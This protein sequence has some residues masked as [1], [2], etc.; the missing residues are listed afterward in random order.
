[1]PLTLGLD[2]CSLKTCWQPNILAC[3]R[4]KQPPSH[5]CRS[6]AWLHCCTTTICQPAFVPSWSANT[7]VSLTRAKAC[8]GDLSVSK[9]HQT[10]GRAVSEC[11][12]LAPLEVP[13]LVGIWWQWNRLSIFKCTEDGRHC[14]QSDV[15]VFM[16]TTQ[17]FSSSCKSCKVPFSKAV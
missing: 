12:A 7:V 2:D 14:C 15:T 3:E 6:P 16:G 10:S 11:I 17:K 5:L 8:D 9:I 1:M 13:G 4:A